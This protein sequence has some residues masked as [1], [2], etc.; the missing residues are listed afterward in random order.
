M[1]KSMRRES[2]W[3]IARICRAPSGAPAAVGAGAAAVLG[4]ARRASPRAE[5][6]SS[7]RL[8]LNKMAKKLRKASISCC[9]KSPIFQNTKGGFKGKAKVIRRLAAARIRL[10]ALRNDD[11]V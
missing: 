3:R 6:I 1:R 10:G 5:A 4:A 2:R 7:G 8:P 11:V 9:K